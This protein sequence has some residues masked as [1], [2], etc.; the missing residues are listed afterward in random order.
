MIK[1][2]TLT[3]KRF[4]F[5]AILI[6]TTLTTIAQTATPP[7]GTGK[8]GDPFQ[9]ATLDNLYWITQDSKLWSAGVFFIQ[10]ADI[11]AKNTNGW[12]KGEGFSPIYQGER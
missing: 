8:S 2:P 1:S 10:T 5:S 4:V 6:L 12:E 11:N 7:S 9:I 3:L